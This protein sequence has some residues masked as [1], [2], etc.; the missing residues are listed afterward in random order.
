M[1]LGTRLHSVYF[2]TVNI[3]KQFLTCVMRFNLIESL[4]VVTFFHALNVL[5][6]FCVQPKG[7]QRRLKE[8]IAWSETVSELAQKQAARYDLLLPEDAG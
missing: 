7:A 4:T 2:V 1:H 5:L 3:A 8:A 6:C